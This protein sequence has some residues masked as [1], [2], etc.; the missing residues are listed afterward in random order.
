MEVKSYER[1]NKVAMFNV[2]M[3]HTSEYILKLNEDYFAKVKSSTAKEIIKARI[4][5]FEEQNKKW[6]ELRDR[7][8]SQLEKKKKMEAEEG[9]GFEPGSRMEVI[10]ENEDGEEIFNIV[11]YGE[12]EQR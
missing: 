5:H 12:G 2:L 6:G 8:A 9:A 7:M 4:G 10:G 1:V 11:E 3:P